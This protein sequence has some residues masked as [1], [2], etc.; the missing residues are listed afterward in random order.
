MVRRKLS[1]NGAALSFEARD[2]TDH[3]TRRTASQIWADPADAAVIGIPSERWGETILA[4]LVT[5]DGKPIDTDEVIAFCRDRLAGYKIP[6][7][8]KCIEEI[9]RNPSG[10]VLKKDLREPY[11]EGIERRVG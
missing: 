6:R 5:R 1:E 2:R 8:V 7:E 10:K 3:T 9:P 11:W 4:F